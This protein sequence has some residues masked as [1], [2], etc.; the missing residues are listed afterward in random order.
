M[1]G[2]DWLKVQFRLG[3]LYPGKV[4]GVRGPMTM[5]GVVGYAA[6]T[7][8]PGGDAVT[9]RGRKLHEMMDREG[10]TTGPR[11][12]GILSNTTHETGDYKRLRE[13]LYYTTAKQIRLT[14]P[15]RFATDADAQPY[16]RNPEGLANKVYARPKEG[17]TQPGDG[18]RYRGGGDFQTT[19]RNGYRRTGLMMGLPLEAHP[20]LIE[21]PAISLMAGIAFW[22]MSGANAY[23]D[24][25]RVK[26]YRS[27]ANAG[28]EDVANPIGWPDVE[29]RYN[30]LLELFA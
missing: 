9:L 8:D 6:P 27:L 14:W 25:G 15:S 2:I 3:R 13:N 19:F 11:L 29:A 18:W 22:R 17:N 7:A 12:A 10:L 5:I 16:V 23:F 20:E 4:D 30:R 1:T 28:R 24:A 26:Q 21:A